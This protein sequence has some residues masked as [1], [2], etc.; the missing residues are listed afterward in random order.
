MERV[1]G[2]V[3]HKYTVFLSTLPD[4]LILRVLKN[5]II[6]LYIDMVVTI[7][8]ALCNSCSSVISFEV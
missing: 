1:I 6:V 2:V 7:S 3:R 8:C 4:Q 5:K